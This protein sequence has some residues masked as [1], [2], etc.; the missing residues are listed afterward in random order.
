M[1]FSDYAVARRSS[2]PGWAWPPDG[3][4]PGFVST[5]VP[6]AAVGLVAATVHVVGADPSGDA[7]DDTAR[8]CSRRWLRRSQRCRAACL[9]TPQAA[10]T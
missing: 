5:S 6:R 4:M 9:E 1:I 10:A 8:C 2:R 3:P 7:M